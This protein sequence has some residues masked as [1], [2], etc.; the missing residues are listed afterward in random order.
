MSFERSAIS[1]N[2]FQLNSFQAFKPNLAVRCALMKLI[3]MALFALTLVGCTG[4]VP[5]EF[6]LFDFETDADLDRINWNCFTLFE[7]S[8]EHF[9][10]GARSLKMDLYPSNY[11][12]WHPNLSHADWSGYRHLVF[13]LFNPQSR[14]M[15][16]TIRID[17]S[18][19]AWNYADRYNQAFSL[20]SGSNRIRIPLETLMTSG[21]ARKMN[22]EKIHKFMLFLVRPQ[23]AHVLYLDHVRLER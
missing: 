6:T 16:V 23:K 20:K 14:E 15:S 19:N 3:F 22:L 13:D 5:Q 9:T 11:P 12:G 10:Q 7:L 21:T 17:D 18:Q 2:A 4:E 1:C 8:N